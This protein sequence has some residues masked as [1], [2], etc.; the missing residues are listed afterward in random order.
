MGGGVVAVGVNRMR[1]DPS[2]FPTHYFEPDDIS[3]HAEVAALK[4]LGGQAKGAKVYIA[5]WHPR[6]NN[7]SLSRPCDNCYRALEKAGVK[8]II[9]TS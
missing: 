1:N 4:A 3:V 6:T 9:Y 7:T 2:R 8:E 5:R